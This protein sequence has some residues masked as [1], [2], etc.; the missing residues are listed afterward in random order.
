M[1]R[2][3]LLLLILALGLGLGAD[4]VRNGTFE[5][6]LQYWNVEY[7]SP[8]SSGVWQVLIGTAYDP[9]P[10][11]EVYIYKFN[12]NY[13][14]I[15]QTVTP[16]TLN[17]QFSASAKLLATEL[18]G[19]GWWAYA[20]V[21]IEYRG[22]FNVLLGRTMIIRKTPWCTIRDDSTR[23]LI[24]VTSDGWENYSF[25]LAEELLNLPGVNPND[26]ATIDLVLESVSIGQEC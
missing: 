8:D 4:L 23:H 17:A 14:R 12:R 20:S 11:K 15:R 25:N 18:T 26:I 21:T 16:T 3:V 2:A 1:H 13:A 7:D 24:V 6:N 19:M 10:D 9:D 22:Q 5:G